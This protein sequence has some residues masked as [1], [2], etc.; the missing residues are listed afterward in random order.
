MKARG[1]V[2]TRT[3]WRPSRRTRSLPPIASS[4]ICAP[5]ASSNMSRRISS[6]RTSS[7]GGPPEGSPSTS[8]GVT[9]STG[10][11]TP[12]KVE[13]TP[14]D[15]L[16]D[17][18]WDMKPR[19]SG[20]GQSLGGAG[21]QDFWT[22]QGIEGSSDV[23]VAVVDTGL[24][25]TPIR[26]SPPRPIS[27]P[28]GTWSPIRAWAMTATDAT[29]IRTIRGISAIRPSPARQTPSTEHMSP[30]PS[31]QP[32]PTMALAWQAEPGT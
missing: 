19:G 5:P 18:Q 21:F 10:S 25:M 6:S 1:D 29:P 28:A 14:N 11:T 20:E 4:T 9:P 13:V 7:C 23:V 3:I 24:Q 8:D 26:T 27:R 30:E 15:P 12:V 16:W 22:R 31:A 2:R 17:L 32:L